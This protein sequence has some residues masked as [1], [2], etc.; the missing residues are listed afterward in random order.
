MSESEFNL[1]RGQHALRGPQSWLLAAA[2]ASC[3]VHVSES[4]TLRQSYL[5]L[6]VWYSCQL[7]VW[8]VVREKQLPPHGLRTLCIECV[9]RHNGYLL[10][11]RQRRR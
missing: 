1:L 9:R 11:Q 4:D 6:L 7:G 5:Y 3:R 8:C 10:F 2:E